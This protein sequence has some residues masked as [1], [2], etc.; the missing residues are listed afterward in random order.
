[1]AL[2]ATLMATLLLVALAGMLAPLSLIET[3][4][5]VNHR[6]AVQALYA[7][8]AALELATAELGA[9]AD[10]SAALNGSARSAFRDATL[11]PA[12]PDG[13]SIDLVA[14]AAG[15]RTG[16]A[17]ST[18]AGRGL[19]WRL[20]AHGRLSA[21][22]AVPADYGPWFVAVWI[23]DDAADPDA[24]PA[25]DGNDSI[26]A[27]AAAFGPRGARRAVQATLVRQFVTPPAPAPVRTRV[28][29]AS[30]SVVR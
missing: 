30:W 11:T 15:L 8:A 13:A 7:A 18:A 20:F 2:L 22:A 19:E 29:L 3:A 14:I 4:V 1:M 17:G 5:G 21:W 27:H 10:W 26:V 9:L 25:L 28:R 24:D 16:G 23:A 12:M 6:R